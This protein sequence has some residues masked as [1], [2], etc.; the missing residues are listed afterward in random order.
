MAAIANRDFHALFGL[1]SL[2]YKPRSGSRKE[3]PWAGLLLNIA[4]F[5][6]K[7]PFFVKPSLN[8]LLQ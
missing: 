3:R 8:S 2:T 7:S 6:L 1:F 5:M 4:H